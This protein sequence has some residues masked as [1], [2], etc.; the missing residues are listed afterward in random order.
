MFQ[1]PQTK[2]LPEKKATAWKKVVIRMIPVVLVYINVDIP[3]FVRINLFEHTWNK[4]GGTIGDLFVY[5]SLTPPEINI[6]TPTTRRA[7]VCAALPV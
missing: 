5:I 4:R 6:T 3:E 2:F 7:I 1:K